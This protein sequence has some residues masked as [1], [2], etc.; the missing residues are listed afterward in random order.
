MSRS[1]NNLP[2]V[3]PLKQTSLKPPRAVESCLQNPRNRSSLSSTWSTYTED[4][5]CGNFGPHKVAKINFCEV[6]WS[7]GKSPATPNCR[8]LAS[9]EQ[10]PTEHFRYLR[11]DMM[12]AS[13]MAPRPRSV[14]SGLSLFY[15]N[16]W[17]V[18]L[19]QA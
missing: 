11:T 1:W 2:F 17:F 5:P 4:L 12:Q 16:V 9:H 7:L 13:D 8:A 19:M 3:K 18:G 14:L 10:Y 6:S 15:A